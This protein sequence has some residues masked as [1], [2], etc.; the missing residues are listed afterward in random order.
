MEIG[1]KFA[2]AILYLLAQAAVD[3]RLVMLLDY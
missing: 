3:N 2:F 1:A